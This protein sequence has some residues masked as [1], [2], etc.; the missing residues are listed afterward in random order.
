MNLDF[1]CFTHEEIISMLENNNIVG[2][3]ADATDFAILLG[4]STSRTKTGMRG[5]WISEVTSYHV[6]YGVNKD[7]KLLKRNLKYIDG[8]CI[9][10]A[11]DASNIGLGGKWNKIGKNRENI[12]MS[13]GEMPQSKIPQ[14]SD[15]QKK[16][17]SLWKNN[18]IK[19]TGKL[20]KFYIKSQLI[21]FK[22]FLY[23][24]KKYIAVDCDIK[25]RAESI[26]SSSSLFTDGVSVSKFNNVIF[27]EVEPIIWVV[28]NKNNLVY[29][30]KLLFSS[31]PISYKTSNV[32]NFLNNQFIE[33]IK[34]SSIHD[35][36]VEKLNISI[37]PIDEI[38][39]IKYFI[40]CNIPVFVHGKSGSGKSDRIKE[41]DPDCTIIYMRNMTPE[42]LIGKTIVVNNELVDIPPTWYLNIVDKCQKEP[43][44]IHILFFDELTNALPSIQ[45]MAFNIVLNREINGKWK[46]PSNVRIVAAGNELEDSLAAYELAE[47]LYGRFA[48]IY[49]ETNTDNWFDWAIKNNIHPTIIA[50]IMCYGNS[51]LRSKYTGETPNADPRKWEMASKVLHQTKNPYMLKGL[52]GND[53][54]NTFISFISLKTYKIKDILDDNTIYDIN[55]S[56]EEKYLTA[57]IMSNVEE[58]NKDKVYGFIKQ[59]GYGPTK[60]FELLCGRQNY[61]YK[62]RR[63]IL[64]R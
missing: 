9:R 53:I 21:K 14:S 64:I 45:S 27:F 48:H 52:V 63:K 12:L 60:L 19:Y 38:S 41:I 17:T 43:E 47:P 23:N 28:D 29:T 30:D 61:I 54:T 16:L 8:T 59:L 26:A 31:F 33:N 37:Q 39:K 62:E 40:D 15:L 13:F 34:P 57:C 5:S 32:Y 49:I 24:G 58:E 35:K 42:S 2:L 46:L 25:K 4:A 50:F 36:E 18:N 22:E 7:G 10:V 56:D 44:K 55:M 1:R 20:Y 11:T 3:S 51:V 6:V